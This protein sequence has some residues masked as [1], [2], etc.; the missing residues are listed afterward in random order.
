[1]LSI[2]HDTLKRSRRSDHAN[3][4]FSAFVVAAA[5]CRRAG[6]SYS[7]ATTEFTRR[8]LVQSQRFDCGVV[9]GSRDGQ[10]VVALEIRKRCSRLNA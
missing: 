3:P 9:D 8:F 10:P 4:Y 7:E 1:M 6:G 2:K 5:L